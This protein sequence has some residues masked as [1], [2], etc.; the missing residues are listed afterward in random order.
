MLKSLVKVCWIDAHSPYVLTMNYL[1]IQT[2]RDIFMMKGSG[3]YCISQVIQFS[4]TNNVRPIDLCLRGDEMHSVLYLLYLPKM[5]N[6]NLIM[7]KQANQDCGIFCKIL[8]LDSS[9]ICHE[10]QKKLRRLLI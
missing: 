5:F 10:R 1:F 8:G 9:K 7:M 4:I 6:E 3:G 2:K